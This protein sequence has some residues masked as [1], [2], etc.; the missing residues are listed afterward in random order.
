MKLQT[1]DEAL[2]VNAFEQEVMV[3]PFSDLLIRNPAETFAEIR[4]WVVTHI[5]A[6][7][8][9]SVK[10]NNLYLGQTKTNEGSRSRSLRVNKTTIE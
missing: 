3:E 2:M 5:N 7:E 4:W 1:H 6:E 9:V 8:A 10:H